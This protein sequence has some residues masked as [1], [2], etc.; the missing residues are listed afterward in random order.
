MHSKDECIS[1]STPT[2]FKS[3]DTNVVT[4]SG[5]YKGHSDWECF[6]LLTKSGSVSRSS[7][8]CIKS[9]R[10]CNRSADKNSKH[11]GF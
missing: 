9:S 4:R 5:P 7:G 3:L 11:D 6:F 1:V 10:C 2:L 8:H